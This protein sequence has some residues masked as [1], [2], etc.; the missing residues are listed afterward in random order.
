MTE[1]FFIYNNKFYPA[2]FAI[3]SSEN[4]SLRYGDGLFETM[5]M[6]KGTIINKEFHFERLFDGL[7]LLQFEIPKAFNSLFLEKKI[8]AIAAKNKHDNAARVRLMLF[9]GD[10]GI[11]DAGNAVPGYIIETSSLPNEN[12]LN[13]NGLVIDVYPG[14]KKVVIFCQ[15]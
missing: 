12:R 14:A 1:H 8:K 9:R 13:E 7:S 6:V 5:R 15:T 2:N 4:R 3:I 11:F 10:R